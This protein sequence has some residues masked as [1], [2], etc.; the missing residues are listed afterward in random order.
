MDHASE[1][2]L[3]LEALEAI[4]ADELQPYSGMLPDGWAA[5]GQTYK[6]TIDPREEGEVRMGRRAAVR[7]RPCA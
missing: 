5:V 4:F 7:G 1:Q 2:A 3:E 6:I